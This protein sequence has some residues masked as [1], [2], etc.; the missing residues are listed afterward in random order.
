MERSMADGKMW[1]PEARDQQSFRQREPLTSQ[2]TNQ[3]ERDQRTHA[4]AKDSELSINVVGDDMG[5]VDNQRSKLREGGL[6]YAHVVS[7]QLDRPYLQLRCKARR[8]RCVDVK[9]PT[10]VR[11]AVEHKPRR[12]SGPRYHDPF[13]RDG[14]VLASRRRGF[15]CL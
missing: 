10:S 3:F 5:E 8:P 12:R 6:R 9:A 7:G 13:L 4:V 15:R 1:R 14:H 2:L 11:E